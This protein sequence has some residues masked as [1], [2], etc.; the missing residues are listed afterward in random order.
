MAVSD[1]GNAI[2]C[3]QTLKWQ[4]KNTLKA[5]MLNIEIDQRHIPTKVSLST[6]A[7]DIVTASRIS[8]ANLRNDLV[9]FKK[10]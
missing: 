8:T 2:S 1:T 5:I 6:P 3:K 4:L 10:N 7:K 9:S